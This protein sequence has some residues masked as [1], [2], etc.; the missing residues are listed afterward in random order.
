MVCCSSWYSHFTATDN[1]SARPP[2]AHPQCEHVSFFALFFP[3]FA[4]VCFPSSISFFLVLRAFHMYLFCFCRRRRYTLVTSCWCKNPSGLGAFPSSNHSYPIF[5]EAPKRETVM[6][7][8]TKWGLDTC[9]TGPYQLGSSCSKSGPTPR[10]RVVEPLPSVTCR[11]AH[12]GLSGGP[13]WRCPLHAAVQ[14]HDR[15]T[16]AHPRLVPRLAASS[17]ALSTSSPLAGVVIQG[18]GPPSTPMK[19]C[20]PCS[21]RR[22]IPVSPSAR[23]CKYTAPSARLIASRTA[24]TAHLGH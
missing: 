8:A 21:F 17:E 14:R 12:G 3:C 9:V 16:R 23:Y 4:L 18:S 20:R 13:L 5:S 2:G 19:R 15:Y 22:C 11:M 6:A 1:G 7:S 10:R 24:A